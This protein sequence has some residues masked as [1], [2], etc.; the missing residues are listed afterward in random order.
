[1]HANISVEVAAAIVAYPT[2]DRHR[3][4]NYLVTLN[5]YLLIIV[6]GIKVTGSNV[7]FE[8]PVP[9]ERKG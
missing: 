6:S 3:F 7:G 8:Y 2:V 5:S 4:P 1:M 9:K